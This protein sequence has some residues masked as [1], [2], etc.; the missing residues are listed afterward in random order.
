MSLLYLSA[1]EV[2]VSA[3][4]ERKKN[5]ILRKMSVN[6]TVCTIIFHTFLDKEIRHYRWIQ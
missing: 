3:D 6:D 5:L 2:E 4:N 1:T